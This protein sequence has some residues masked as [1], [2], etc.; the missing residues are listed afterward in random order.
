[1]TLADILKAYPYGGSVDLST[2]K[3]KNVID[4]NVNNLSIVGTANIEVKLSVTANEFE[5]ASIKA[6]K[7]S[8]GRVVQ[9]VYTVPKLVF[10]PS[11]EEEN[12]K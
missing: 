2:L 12:K 7:A 4:K 6:I 3:R 10:K 1:M 8:K 11:E 5:L 9:L